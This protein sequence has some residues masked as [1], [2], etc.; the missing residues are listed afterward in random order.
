MRRSG[1][2]I[3]LASALSLGLVGRPA[4]VEG[5]THLLIVSGLGGDAKF[6]DAFK[7]LGLALSTA[8]HQ[9]YGLPDSEIVLLAEDTAKGGGRIAARSTKEEI[10]RALERFRARA[11]ASDQLVIVLIG[12]GSPEGADSKISLPGPDMT[13][14]DFAKDLAK[15]PTQR[16]AFV[17]ATS[18]SGDFLP[19]LSAPNRVVIT[20]TKSSFERNESVFAAHFVDALTKDGADTDKDGR[21]SLLEAFQ[22][23][24]AETKRA[25]EQDSKLQTEHAQLDDDG[26]HKG[27]PDPDGKTEGLLARRFFLDTPGAVARGGSPGDVQLAALYKDKSNLEERI[28]ALKKK[29]TSMTEDA[30]D[31]ALEELLVQLARKSL[32]IRQ[33]E[34]RS[35]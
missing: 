16:V 28:D 20:A 24:T 17:N 6:A 15:W 23:A 30:Y 25:Y 14:A 21:I 22:Y 5:Q 29:K 10:E 35:Q 2:A 8:A 26:D 31:D 11:G 18:A 12:H 32:S 1:R 27:S 34:G 9:R 33:L 13:A 19:V 4:R 3:A 7:T